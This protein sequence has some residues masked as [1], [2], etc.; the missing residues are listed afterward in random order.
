MN[1]ILRDLFVRFFGTPPTSSTPF[2]QEGSNR[3][4]FRLANGAH[5]AI[6][7]LNDNRLENDAF[8]YFAKHFA[9]RGV[10]VPKILAEDLH[11][12]AYLETDLG[13]Q[14][15]MSLLEA[16]RSVAD[17]FPAKVEAQYRSVL[18]ELIKIQTHGTRELDFSKCHP[19]P[20]YDR[21]SMLWDMN[22]FKY[23]FLK[24]AEIP[25]NERL[26]EDDFQV[27]SRFLS[28]VPAD[29]FMHR[30]FQSRNIM[31]KDSSVYI[32]D[33]Q[34]GVKG[35]PHYD[36]AA[37]LFQPSAGITQEARSRLLDHYLHEV[38]K[39]HPVEAPIFK[40]HFYGFVFLRIMQACGAYG[41]RGLYGRR[42]YFIKS[43]PRMA[44]NI[45]ELL[46][47]PGLPIEVPE[48]SRVFHRIATSL[49][50]PDL[51]PSPTKLAVSI[52]SFSYR[53]GLPRSTSTHG[54]GFVFDCRGIPNPGREEELKT[55]TGKD[56]PVKAFLKKDSRA[57]TFARRVT[58]IVDQTVDRY[59]E[60]GFA[61][62][63]VAFGCTGGQHRSVFF[64]EQ[65]LKHLKR[66]YDIEVTIKHLEFPEI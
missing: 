63:S 18:S 9:S 60:R 40:R 41:L 22:Y 52:C 47:D 27:L 62:L 38:S 53:G 13:G 16:E 25:F 30:D 26:L 31:L 59:I 34:G 32:I 43:I 39:I 19:V 8:C 20:S 58:S 7:V 23:D 35:P 4:R 57:R 66:K 55:L 15:L 48:L 36:V 3:K 61:E 29:V 11:H 42:S 5:S 12:G 37:L 44:R 24:L 6:G 65:L 51:Q 21:T 50:T 1:V 64:A 54:G 46:G 49:I 33:F 10:H 56:R 28:E 17:P 45:G 2:K 14:T